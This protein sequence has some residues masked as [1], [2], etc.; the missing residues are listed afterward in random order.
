MGLCVNEKDVT[1]YGAFSLF[2]SAGLYV[3]W[4]RATLSYSL[5]YMNVAIIG[6]FRPYIIDFDPKMVS[7]R[8]RRF[9]ELIGHSCFLALSSFG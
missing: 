9:S 6:I 5:F 2:G 1:T 7:T 4:D 3:Y 8:H